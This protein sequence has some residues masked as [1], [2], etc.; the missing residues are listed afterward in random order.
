MDPDTLLDPGLSPPEDSLFTI[1]PGLADP[2]GV[3]FESVSR[4]GSYLRH[5]VY[6]LQLDSYIDTMIYKEDATYY[7]V[8]GLADGGWISY[9]SYNYPNMYIIHRGSGVLGIDPVNDTTDEQNA[10]FREV[11]N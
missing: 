1:V 2:A 6:V 5:F 7:R 8:A 10:T 11:L 4:P 9:Q 3:S